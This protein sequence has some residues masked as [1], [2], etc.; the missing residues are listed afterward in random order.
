MRA[1][2]NQ[3]SVNRL[4]FEQK[5]FLSE[6]TAALTTSEEQTKIDWGSSPSLAEDHSATSH[7][8]RPSELFM[9]PSGWALFSTADRTGLFEILLRTVF[10]WLISFF[11][12]AYDHPQR[13]CHPTACQ[14]FSKHRQLNARGMWP[15]FFFFFLN[16]RKSFDRSRSI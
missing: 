2:T 15:F 11:S 9:S 1:S 12:C 3:I 6:P 8:P 13:W 5:D 4:V 10:R 14:T 16:R 7:L